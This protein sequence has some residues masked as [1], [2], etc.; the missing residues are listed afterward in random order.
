M[1][2]FSAKAATH[3]GQL[4]V[5]LRIPCETHDMLIAAHARGKGAMLSTNNVR[6]FPKD[7]GASGRQLGLDQ[8]GVREQF[9]YTASA[10]WPPLPV[11]VC[12]GTRLASL[13]LVLDCVH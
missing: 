9:G 5:R 11:V 3:F 6:E 13:Y 4:R 12:A 7:A 10:I 8:H 2:S 1:S